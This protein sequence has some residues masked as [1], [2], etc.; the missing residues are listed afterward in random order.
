MPKRE[1]KIQ[2]CKSFAMP[3]QVCS[4]GNVFCYLLEATQ[5]IDVKNIDFIINEKAV[6]R[7]DVDERVGI[8][9]C[10]AKYRAGGANAKVVQLSSLRT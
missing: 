5:G 1:T 10:S 7:D 8:A 4:P 9:E 6:V 3:I 2:S